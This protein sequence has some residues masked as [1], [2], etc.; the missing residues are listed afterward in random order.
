[1]GVGWHLQHSVVTGGIHD[2]AFL[3]HARVDVERRHP[4]TRTGARRQY[5]V[6][7]ARALGHAHRLHLGEDLQRALEVGLGAPVLHAA[8]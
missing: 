7:R 3:R 8:H 6:I 1:M 4:L 2:D 5:G